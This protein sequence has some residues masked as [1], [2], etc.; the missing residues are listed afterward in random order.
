MLFVFLLIADCE[1]QRAAI[2]CALCDAVA[3]SF[4]NVLLTCM[5]CHCGMMQAMSSPRPCEPWLWQWRR[6]GRLCRLCLRTLRMSCSSCAAQRAALPPGQNADPRHHSLCEWRDRQELWE[7]WK[8]IPW[9]SIRRPPTRHGCQLEQ[10][11]VCS[12]INNSSNISFII[13]HQHFF[14]AIITYKVSFQSQRCC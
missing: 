1:V 4:P 3:W 9:R 8:P 13:L 11:R 6:A 5:S 14:P 7:Y 10:I 2:R 12:E